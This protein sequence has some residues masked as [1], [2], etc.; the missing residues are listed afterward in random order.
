[1][2]LKYP[3]SFEQDLT[4]G[5]SPTFASTTS[6]HGRLTLD[7]LDQVGQSTALIVLEVP[8]RHS[9]LAVLPLTLLS[10]QGQV[11]VREQVGVLTWVRQ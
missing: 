2:G 1:M 11:Y 6:R 7:L 3:R 4:S 10:L 9:L 5:C 8:S